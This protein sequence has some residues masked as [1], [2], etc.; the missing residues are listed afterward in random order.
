VFVERTV[1]TANQVVRIGAD[2]PM[3]SASLLGCA[4]LTG[5]GA[6]LNRARV[7]RGDTTIVI[8][9][10]GVGLNVVQGC[11]LAGASRIV[12][13]DVNPARE[14]LARRFGATDFVDAAPGDLVT[15]VR[16]V[17]PSGAD[18]VFECVGRTALIRA[19]IDL[20]DWH[21]QCVMVGVP[22]ATEEVSFPVAQMYL[23][24][25]IL[26]LRYGSS[27]PQADI[28]F[29][30]DLY[31]RGELLLDELVTRTYPLEDIRVVAED[32]ARGRIAR[33]VL[34]L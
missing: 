31:R 13:V 33:G 23:D 15:A 3:E 32:M 24:R 6:A 30:L 20:L 14:E 18:H 21:G 11:R 12:A 22:A 7:A 28:P 34:T 17:L 4:V 25:S 5:V 26:G 16:A 19:A 27:R 9:V 29:Y 2:V 1:V 10:G 8:G